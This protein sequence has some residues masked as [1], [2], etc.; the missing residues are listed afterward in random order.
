MRLLIR[1]L[2]FFISAVLKGQHSNFKEVDFSKAD[3]IATHYKG[4]SLKNLPILTHNLTAN[5]KTDV[6]KFRAIYTWVSSNIKNDYSAYIRTI[7][8]RKKFIQDKEALSKWNASTTPKV[9]KTLLEHKKT[10][11]SGYAYLIRELAT[12]ANIN[13]KI[14]NGYGRTATTILTNKS[15]PNHSW[16][17]AE[18]N[19][20]WYLCDA[21]WSA[22]KIV[23]DDNQPRFEADYF[24]GY[25]L[26]N[27]T[28]FIK[29]HYPLETNWTLLDQN[30][31][32]EDFIDGPVVYKEAYK[33]AILIHGPKQMRLQTIKNEKISFKFSSKNRFKNEDITLKLKTSNSSKTVIPKVVKNKNDYTLSYVF[34]KTGYFD[35]HIIVEEALIAT[36][37]VRVKRN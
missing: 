16:N 35:V 3:S 4:A 18:L 2:P 26:A 30:P 5:L 13:C 36:Y 27:P 25:F 28:L 19:G 8:K 37:V 6:E 20:E 17:A 33:K 32:F 22:G 12:L 11:C 1:L 7:K 34:E 21:T 15:I 9:F 23:L 10:A 29:N 31:S 24:D 14:I